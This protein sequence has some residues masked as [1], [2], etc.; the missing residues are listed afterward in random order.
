MKK[1][2]KV[3]IAL[4]LFLLVLLLSFKIFQQLQWKKKMTTKLKEMPAFRCYTVDS[5]PFTS[6]DINWNGPTVFVFY[7]PDC[8]SCNQ[9]AK[10]ILQ[11]KSSLDSIHLLLVS[12]CSILAMKQFGD[13]YG[14]SAMSGITLLKAGPGDIYRYFGVVLTPSF[15]IYNSDRHLVNQYNGE[16][17]M[18]L[19]LKSLL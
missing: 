8:E 2:L 14:F 3:I 5:L 16:T 1:S 9:E 19:V 12:D 6:Q 11:H 15:L 10:D 7:Q 4:L 17:R 18:D 13:K